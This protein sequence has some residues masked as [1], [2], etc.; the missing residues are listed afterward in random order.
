MGDPTAVALVS[1]GVFGEKPEWSPVTPMYVPLTKMA[2]GLPLLMRTRP[3]GAS[4]TV[5]W[6]GMATGLPFFLTAWLSM[7]LPAGLLAGE[8]FTVMMLGR[9]TRLH[10]RESWTLQCACSRLGR[11]QLMAGQ[12]RRPGTGAAGRCLYS[13][14]WL[15]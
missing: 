13:E 11:S 1:S 8:G 2:M 12:R 9:Q 15:E 10:V 14:R 6:S 5:V 3:N 7:L 4:T